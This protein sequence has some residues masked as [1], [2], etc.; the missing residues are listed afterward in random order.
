MN[1]TPLG[2]KKPLP[3]QSNGD[4]T[5]TI[6]PPVPEYEPAPVIM[7]ASLSN[8]NKRRGFKSA[9]NNTAPTKILFDDDASA[10]GSSGGPDVLP[11]SETTTSEMT[12]AAPTGRPRLI[13]P[14]EKQE[15]G[16]LPLNMFVTSVD[17]EEGMWPQKRKKKARAPTIEAEVEYLDYGA[18]EEE[19]VDELI[20]TQRTVEPSK[21]SGGMT[22]KDIEKRWDQ[23]VKV[24]E[25]SQ[26]TVG[27]WLAWKVCRA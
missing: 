17:V 8:K 9:M 2:Q 10:A 19:E 11:F 15:K 7:M 16:L 5:A 22:I 20:S 27:T 3:A 18:A 25:Q 13:P 24:T 14:S 12:K 4:S 21:P 1:E 6:Q 23:L 26:V